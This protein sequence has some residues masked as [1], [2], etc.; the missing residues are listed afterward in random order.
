M[1]AEDRMNFNQIVGNNELKDALRRR[2]NDSKIPHAQLFLGPQGSGSLKLALAFIAYL[3]CENKTEQDSCGSCKACVKNAKLIHP[4]VHFSFPVISAKAPSKSLSSNHIETFRTQVLTHPDM[5]YS[6]WMTAIQAEN[7]QG[8][9]SRDEV[10]AIISGLSLKPFEAKSK[11]LLM[12]LPEY[13]GKEGNAL[14]KL[15]EEPP[16][17]TYFILVAENLDHL[18]PTIISRVQ[19]TKVKALSIGEVEEALS[20][21]D[22]EPVHR[23]NVAFLS[24]GNLNEAYKLMDNTDHTF[25]DSFRDWMRMSFQSKQLDIMKWSDEA[26]SK[27]RE[28]I[29]AFLSFCLA[30]LRECLAYKTIDDYQ[31]RLGEHD[32]EFIKNFSKAVKIV[33]IE[34]LYTEINKTIGE[35]ERNANPKITFLNLSNQIAQSFRETRVKSN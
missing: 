34:T 27:G 17:N 21:L 31:I 24:Q 26:G 28:N 19:I 18:L 10:R 14:L 32:E 11:I 30:L 20:N 4:D 22:M 2:V 25:T 6:D 35:I 15:L 8:N 29:K 33:N 12:W 16:A 23:R 7:K 1:L 13:L 3:L 5:I 9:I